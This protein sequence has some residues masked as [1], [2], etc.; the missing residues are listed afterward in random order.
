M[1]TDFESIREKYS[2]KADANQ[3]VA[4]THI[5]GPALVLAGPGSG[6]TTVIVARTIFLLETTMGNENILTVAFNKAASIEMRQ[7]F[8]AR[9]KSAT[10]CASFSTFHSFCNKIIG[11][12]EKKTG[13]HFI[14]LSQT[15]DSES[16]GSDKVIAKIYEKV[17]NSVLSEIE[18]NKLAN[19][20]SCIKNGLSV[21]SAKSGSAFKRL[22]KV[23][24]AYDEYKKS[25]GMIDFDDMLYFSKE[26]LEKDF[27]IL[28][29]V[30]NKYKFIQVDEGQDLSGIQMAILKLI[31]RPDEE[32]VFIVGDDDQGIYGFRGARPECIINIDEYFKGCKIYK[33]ER[34]YR[35]TKRIVELASRFVMKNEKR[36]DKKHFTG[37]DKGVKPACRVFH[38]DDE[39]LAFLYSKVANKNCGTCGIL[40]RNGLSAIL[41]AIYLYS[42]GVDFSMGKLRNSFFDHWMVLDLIGMI[43]GLAKEESVIDSKSRFAIQV[44]PEKYLM[45]LF[46]NEGYMENAK[47]KSE[48]LFQPVETLDRIRK[49][50]ELLAH[51]TKLWHDFL[52]KYI[53]I[54]EMFIGENVGTVNKNVHMSTVHGAKGLEY[55]TV[56]MIDLYKGEFPGKNCEKD[57]EEERRLFFVGMTRAKKNLYMMYPSKRCGKKIEAGVFFNEVKFLLRTLK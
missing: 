56:F 9:Y 50:F 44:R 38:D 11:V 3:Q 14:R 41:P 17:N 39:L 15:S 29:A 21:A 26:I 1:D 16:M 43:E 7:R 57:L 32:D 27:E 51:K 53:S 10:E 34:N 31:A 33:L 28:N 36:Y 47:V 54:K 45:N 2:L 6:K 55:D 25:K 4:I 18:V 49:A 37:N 12:Y 35:S 5:D 46:D 24:T 42:N 19:E 40:F 13:K 8:E 23:A 48:I 20:V 22:D 52:E 30:R